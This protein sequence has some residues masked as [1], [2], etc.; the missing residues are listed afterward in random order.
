MEFATEDDLAIFEAVKA[1]ASNELGAAAA[2]L[3]ESGAFA[4]RHLPGLAALGVMGLNL[5][6]RWGGAGISPVALFLAVE[7][8]AAACAST[9]SMVTAHYLATDAILIGGDDPIRQRYL[10]AAARGETL[11]AFA[12]TEPR[13]GSA[14]ADMTTRAEAVG[15]G[16]YRLS[17]AKH[18]ISNAGQADFI[19]VFAVTDASLGA[20]GISAFVVDKGAPG[21]V[22]GPPEPTMGLKGGHIF[23]VAFDCEIGEDS[24]L[25]PEGTGFR[26]AMKALDN[27]RIEIAATCVGI[28]EA[29]LASAIAWAKA[30]RIKGAPIAEFQGVQWMLADMSTQLEAARL[31]SLRAASKRAQGVRFSNEAAMAKL[32]A[33]EMAAKVTD[34]ALQIHGGYGYS[35]GLP[36]ER[37]VRDVRV[38]RIYEGSSEIQRNIIAR[39]LIG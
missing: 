32:F 14:P 39:G 1:F 15:A 13:A 27:G 4:G 38:M 36:L 29:A 30:R 17:G 35:R 28:A 33:S 31:L 6:E 9:T 10:P 20:R 12:L 19:V 18:F 25:G 23:E 3:D 22:I 34:L 37:Y 26:T 21:I 16:R 11:G 7:A 24:R 8:L 2:S 5:P